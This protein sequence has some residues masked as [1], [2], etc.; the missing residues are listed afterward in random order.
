MKKLLIL[1]SLTFA[2]IV[3][4]CDDDD[5]STTPSQQNTNTNSWI[6]DQMKTYYYWED[7]IPAKPNLRSKPED[8]F[9]SLLYTS[10][11]RYSW[12]QNITELENGFNGISVS[13]GF[14]LILY[15][16]YSGSYNL[17]GQV[18]Y[19]AKGGPAYLVG[20]K[21]GDLFTSI[22]GQ[23]LNFDNY[24]S[25]L[26]GE[27][28]TTMKL[29]LVDA[30]LDFVKNV[31]V[32]STLF[33]ESP[34]MGDSIY[35]IENTTVGYFAYKNFISDPGD[36]SF[37]YDNEI[38]QIFTEFKAA[39]IDELIL[40]FRFNTGGSEV[41]AAKI[42]S[43][44]VKG[45]TTN[46][47][48]AYHQYNELLNTELAKETEND[49]FTLK[50]SEEPNNLGGRLDRIVVL[51]SRWT[52]SASE[53]IING[54]RPYMDVVLVGDTTYG[55]NVGSI[56]LSDETKKITWG[57]QPIVVK[58]FNSNM[59]SDYTFG[60]IPDYP[61]EDND[62]VI[63]PLGDTNEKLLNTALVRALGLSS[64]AKSPLKSGNRINTHGVLNSVALKPNAF[65][66]NVEMLD[67]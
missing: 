54:L 25:L 40:D 55:K 27:S 8:F 23:K 15:P 65:M 33:T 21:R 32:V 53:L 61:L 45:A 43:Q 18:T 38:S 5:D 34:I 49:Y 47:V 4:G 50:F 51:T 6:L 62:L 24:S 56:T 2:F 57:L 37:S 63:Y 13:P 46:S 7:Y 52:A 17:I 29:G 48:F 14:E 9:K 64:V 31:T 19:V 28:S 1:F 42:A 44:I 3:V 67:R 39:N 16:T 12:I 59:E 26:V 11:D 22:N 35:H 30:N 58:I 10:E 36:N 41:A 60:F 66:L 20:L